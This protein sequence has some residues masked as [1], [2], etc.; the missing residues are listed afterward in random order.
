[1][2]FAWSYRFEGVRLVTE[3]APVVT[4]E[5]G[6]LPEEEAVQAAFEAAEAVRRLPSN[7]IEFSGGGRSVI[8]FSQ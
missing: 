3:T 6:L 5:R 1:M 8:L 7:G 2:K 4:C